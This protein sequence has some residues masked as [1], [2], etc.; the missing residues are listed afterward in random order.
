MKSH[1]VIKESCKKRGIKKIASDVGISTS[2]LYKWSQPP[3]A[4][5]SGSKNPLDRMINL[6]Q[7][8]NDPQ[9]I[10]WICEQAG[11]YFVRNPN[12]KEEGDYEV[13]PATNEIVSQFS[14]LLSEISKAAQDNA[15]TDNE[16]ERIRKVWN[17]L[18]SFT[19]GFVKC[20]EEGNFNK[21]LE[22]K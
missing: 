4:S 17:A 2:L 19:E 15:I 22:S 18:K 13:M 6:M 5:G 1:E 7:A 10:S 20:C 16:S 21:M 8:A 14:A 12:D 9:M 11:G 3:E